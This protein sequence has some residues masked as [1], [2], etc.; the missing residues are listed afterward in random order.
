M[1]ENLLKQEKTE[2]GLFHG[3]RS[4]SIQ[5][6]HNNNGKT[7]FEKSHEVIHPNTDD[8]LTCE[9]IRPSKTDSLEA[10]VRPYTHQASFPG[11]LSPPMSRT[12]SDV[13]TCEETHQA[14][15][16]CE[17]ITFGKYSGKKITELLKDRNYS[18]WI[19][20]QDWF[21][22]DYTHLYNQ[23]INYNP[24]IF[25]FE[26]TEQ[27][28]ILE[29]YDKNSYKF[30][31]IQDFIECFE[32]FNMKNIQ[33]VVFS[34]EKEHGIIFSKEDYLCY[35][36]YLQILEDIK[37]KILNNIESDNPYNIKAP[38]KWLKR[39]EESKKL[40]RT[41]FKRF[42]KE[43]D[44]V[45]ITSIVEYIK[46][47]G[48][49]DYKGA[50]SY[51]IA[52]DRSVKQE[53]YWEDFLKNKYGENIS[54]QFKYKDC[55]FDFLNIKNQTIYECKLGL[56][57]FNETQYIKYLKTLGNYNIIYI[58]GYDTIIDMKNNK[59]TI[60]SKNP[61]EDNKKLMLDLLENIN[62]LSIQHKDNN[63]Y[64]EWILS[65]K[66]FNISIVSNLDESVFDGRF[67]L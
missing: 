5:K 38:V 45:N 41:E 2:I 52:K 27:S 21:Q 65:L 13:L 8:V 15:L 43:Y 23:V 9:E 36:F 30:N 48:G 16:T 10:A 29:K 12:V 56:K 47:M 58:I 33:D 31:N 3:A 61:L 34:L 18:K 24:S 32:F 17:D 35:E 51:K 50:K 49:I 39:F 40:D 62:K 20:E 7:I 53:K 4:K 59:I 25:F 28:N 57:D 26:N 6:S 46:K 66:K 1:T 63:D 44:L 55:F 64:S 11:T 42:I 22:N 14:S 67:E 19:V 37:Q 54:V 60:L